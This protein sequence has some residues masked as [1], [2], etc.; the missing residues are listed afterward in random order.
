MTLLGSGWGMAGDSMRSLRGPRNCEDS[1]SE[2]RMRE[3]GAG[4]RRRWLPNGCTEIVKV[5]VGHAIRDGM[6]DRHEL[7]S[8]LTFDARPPVAIREA[9]ED[10]DLR[11]M[12]G[13]P[14]AQS[15]DAQRRD[16]LAIALARCE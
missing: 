14:L 1:N 10:H 13:D 15:P 16:V 6:R 9:V 11:P 4:R 3:T 2:F 12:L 7:R 5:L 8:R